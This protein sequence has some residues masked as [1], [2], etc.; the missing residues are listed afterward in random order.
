[1]SNANVLFSVGAPMIS[2]KTTVESFHDSSISPAVRGFLYSPADP[3]SDALILTHGAG[4]NSN[5]PLLIALAEK[6]AHHSYAVLR[7]DLP[8]RQDRPTGPPFPGNA[9]RDREGLRN[10]VGVMRKRH[11]GRIFLAGHSYGGRQSSMLCAED[12]DLV[13]G[14]LLL[15]YPLHPPRKPEQLRT[16]H[17]PNLRTSS[18]FVQGT[19]DPFGSI[20]EVEKALE[21]IPALK[22]LQRIEGAGHDLNFKAK[23]A[24]QELPSRVFDAWVTMIS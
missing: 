4:S 21:L 23:K 8:F 2:I 22:Q 18:L 10:A 24:G 6:F 3:G 14:L 5:S 11:S 7:C 12:P 16:Q 19:R 20:E 9:A 1:V 17:F 15:S 13:S